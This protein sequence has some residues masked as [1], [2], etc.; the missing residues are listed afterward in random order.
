VIEDDP[1]LQPLAYEFH[2]LLHECVWA[3][4]EGRFDGRGQYPLRAHREFLVLAAERRLT[5]S[6]TRVAW[7]IRRREEDSCVSL[8]QT[9]M[10]REL[11]LSRE[12]VNR[13]VGELC[14]LG[15]VEKSG[16][17]KAV[18]YRTVGLGRETNGISIRKCRRW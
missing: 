2:K 8:S 9:R 14:R 4:W 7:A 12:R 16:R 17:G 1:G 5:A 15:A 3:P 18:R 13:V 10:A 11:D 6:Q